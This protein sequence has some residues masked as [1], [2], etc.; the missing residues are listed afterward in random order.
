MVITKPDGWKFNYGDA[1]RKRS[2]LSNLI[3]HPRYVKG[4]KF[5]YFTSLPKHY[6]DFFIHLGSHAINEDF[7]YRFQSSNYISNAMS[8]E[9]KKYDEYINKIYYRKVIG[10]IQFS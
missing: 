10:N 3:K 9:N 7:F 5:I 1:V 2:R 8:Y 6:I 4:R